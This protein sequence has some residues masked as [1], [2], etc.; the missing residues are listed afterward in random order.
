MSL[1][2]SCHRGCPLPADDPCVS[3]PQFYLD[4]NWSSH[5]SE[6]AYPCSPRG[7]GARRCAGLSK[8]ETEKMTK[9]WASNM[10]AVQTAIVTQDGFDWQNFQGVRTPSEGDKCS[11]FFRSACQEGSHIQ[12]NAIQY[13]LQYKYTKDFSSGNLTNFD[14]DLAVFLAS[15]GPYA[16]LGY[17][18]MGCG[19]GWEHGGKMPCDFYERPDALNLDYGE[20]TGLCK[21]TAS[22][23]GVFKREWTKST[24]TVDCNA[25]TSTIKMK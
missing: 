12:S 5:P 13:G 9:G 19:C 20:P 10:Q 1:A 22:G 24:V 18:W 16:W 6:E 21:E 14:M 4:D 15:R 25:Y 23:T 17:G 3:P 2:D 7:T 11:A 8:A